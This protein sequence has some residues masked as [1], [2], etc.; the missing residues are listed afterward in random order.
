MAIGVYRAIRELG[1]EPGRDVPV[2]GYGGTLFATTMYPP[3]TTI[4][5]SGHDL[6]RVS[7]ELLLDLITGAVC[8]PR[9]V[10][11]PWKLD[12]RQSTVWRLDAREFVPAP[13]LDR[14]GADGHGRFD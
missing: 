13:N 4:A 9:Q 11:V 12:V 3:L 7:A 8:G 5:N 14:A 6:G 10:T 2:V 1:R